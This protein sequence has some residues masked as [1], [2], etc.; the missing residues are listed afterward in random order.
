MGRD[1]PSNNLALSNE[2]FKGDKQHL[3]FHLEA[4]QLTNAAAPKQATHAQISICTELCKLLHFEPTEISGYFSR[5]AH[6]EHIT[7]F[8]RLPQKCQNKNQKL[9]IKREMRTYYRI[10]N[11]F[12]QFPVFL[13]KTVDRDHVNKLVLSLY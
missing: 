2:G 10:Q 3:D 12:I 1:G 8:Q 9:C 11:I 13:I 4:K 6:V 5:A 7:V